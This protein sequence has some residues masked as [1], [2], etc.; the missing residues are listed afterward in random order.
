MIAKPDPTM[1]PDVAPSESSGP[2]STVATRGEDFIAPSSNFIDAVKLLGEWNRWLVTVELAMIG[3]IG[4]IL[5]IE[6][7]RG[8]GTS[9]MGWLVIVTAVVAVFCF[10]AS[11]ALAT[12][13][14]GSLPFFVEGRQ[15]R[16][17]QPLILMAHKTIRDGRTQGWKVVR[18]FSWQYRLFVVAAAA[19]AL[20]V[21]S[22]LF[23]DTPPHAP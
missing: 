21:I 5:R 12:G 2:C 17:G 8:I 18:S 10:A 20:F 3:V 13:L 6:E 15:A 23:L 7:R 19:F 14:L 22:L 11:I 9:P 4:A 1:V 16:A